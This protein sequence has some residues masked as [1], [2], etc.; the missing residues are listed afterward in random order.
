MPAGPR[1]ARVCRSISHSA[2]WPS[3]HSLVCAGFKSPQVV[4][5]LE[6]SQSR[7]QDA[8]TFP[9]VL[10]TS[11]SSARV[12]Y[13]RFCAHM[14]CRVLFRTRSAQISAGMAHFP[15]LS[16]PQKHCASVSPVKTRS[17]SAGASTL[18]CPI[19][20]PSNS[21]GILPVLSVGFGV[22]T[23]WDSHQTLSVGTYRLTCGQKTG[24]SSQARFK[25]RVTACSITC[26]YLFAPS[27]RSVTSIIMRL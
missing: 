13:E 25:I 11:S 4:L 22:G 16:H 5:G 9:R 14:W 12:E 26:R 10:I 17:F 7:R 18:S 23:R 8:W 2:S 20:T 21:L 3:Y 24:Q 15:K 6:A 1:V 19:S 27:V